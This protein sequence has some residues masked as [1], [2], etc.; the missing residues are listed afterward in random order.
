MPYFSLKYR[1]NVTL[2]CLACIITKDKDNKN[3]K[4]ITLYQK[5]IRNVRCVRK[6]SAY[7]RS[8]EICIQLIS[9]KATLSEPPMHSLSQ[10]NEYC[11]KI[12]LSRFGRSQDLR[13]LIF[14]KTVNKKTDSLFKC[15][16]KQ[17]LQCK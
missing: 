6:P 12:F 9:R 3:E 13:R 10:K 2:M 4:I 15:S 11:A 17:Q 14:F 5:T 7:G 8:S 1:S 16:Q